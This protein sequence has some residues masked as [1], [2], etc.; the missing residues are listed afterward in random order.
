VGD[1]APNTS[2]VGKVSQQT[3]P[4]TMAAPRGSEIQITVYGPTVMS[5]VVPQLVGAGGQSARNQLE[6]LGLK[7]EFALGAPAERP[8]MEGKVLS[9][10][11]VA[12]AKVEPGTA[13]K[14]FIAGPVTANTNSVIVPDVVGLTEQQALR[15]LAERQ[16]NHE[17]IRAG[18]PP[19]RSRARTIKGQKPPA[20]RR[21][22]INSRVEIAIYGD[23]IPSPGD[24]VA[25][26]D[27]SS[28]P[29]SEAYWDAQ[30]QRARCRCLPGYAPRDNACVRPTAARVDPID[31]CPGRYRHYPNQAIR[32]ANLQSF[33]PK[34]IEECMELCDSYADSS[35]RRCKSFDYGRRHQQCTLSDKNSR[36]DIA[37]AGTPAG[38]T[39]WPYDYYER[40]N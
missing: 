27:C 36:D 8:E 19:D 3:P 31:D 16:L 18:Q 20:G 38:A 32:G 34:T 23:Y 29:D 21:L 7:P 2:M 24:Q 40:C 35:G 6:Q 13:I 14:M 10:S 9:Q 39:D 4:A 5:T 26:A 17:L 37:W 28:I 11:I 15:V 12:G 22:A 25:A 30:R 1:A 33:R